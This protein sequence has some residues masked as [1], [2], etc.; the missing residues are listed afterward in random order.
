M[1]VEL[2]ISVNEL[3]YCSSFSCI[4]S[5]LESLDD[6][7]SVEL[8][9]VQLPS[10]RLVL[11]Q[12]PEYHGKPPISCIRGYINGLFRGKRHLSKFAR[13]YMRVFGAIQYSESRVLKRSHAVQGRPLN[14]YPPVCDRHTSAQAT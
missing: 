3:H 7:C 5:I 14:R 6:S 2:S 9:M 1:R 12:K 4:H 10:L 8:L 13:S 11:C